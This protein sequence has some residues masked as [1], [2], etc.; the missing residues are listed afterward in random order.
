MGKTSFVKV[1]V[2]LA[3]DWAEAIAGPVIS[4]QTA[5]ARPVTH[6]LRSTIIETSKPSFQSTMSA[7]RRARNQT[8]VPRFPPPGAYISSGGRPADV[9]Y[10]TKETSIPHAFAGSYP[11]YR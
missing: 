11:W 10:K 6:R 7:A 8:I 2:G 3:A 9:L 5:S 1:A 4:P